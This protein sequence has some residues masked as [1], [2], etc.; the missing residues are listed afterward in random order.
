MAANSPRGSRALA[1]AFVAVIVTLPA[2]LSIGLAQFPPASSDAA[3][4]QAFMAARAKT[5]DA[6]FAALQAAAAKS[7]AQEITGEIWRQWTQSGRPSIDALMQQA[8]AAMASRNFGLA[9]LMLDEVIDEAPDF[10]EG[11]NRRATLRHSM[12]D[13]EGALADIART[14]ALE[15]RHFGA[16]AGRGMIHRTAGRWQEALA[17]YRAAQPYYRFNADML[18][19]VRDLEKQVAGEKL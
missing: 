11:W 15:P 8:A 12:G 19:L 3:E 5:L 17:A 6:L 18:T 7:E 1:A 2:P 13:P 10:S 16:L 14:L 9:V 4:V